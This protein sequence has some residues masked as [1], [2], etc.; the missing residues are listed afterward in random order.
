MI[1]FTIFVTVGHNNTQN[2]RIFIN[3]F[4]LQ[5]VYITS[6]L[7]CPSKTA[8]SP[9]HSA[10]TEVH[11]GSCITQQY[12]KKSDHLHTVYSFIKLGA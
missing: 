12:G 8:I 6:L 11:S 5:Q 3:L 9:Q 1:F 2:S 7:F 10:F 4:I